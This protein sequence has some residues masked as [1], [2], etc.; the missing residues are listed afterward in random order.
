VTKSAILGLLGFKFPQRPLLDWLCPLPS[1]SWQDKYNK[2]RQGSG[3]W[4]L[5][6]DV[7]KSWLKGDITKVWCEGDRESLIIS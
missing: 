7:I 5:E 3:A 2:S 1:Q 6:L 4:F